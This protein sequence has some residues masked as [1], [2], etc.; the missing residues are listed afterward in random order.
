MQGRPPDGESALRV[1]ARLAPV[2]AGTWG[3]AGVAAGTAL[4]RLTWEVDTVRALALSLSTALAVRHVVN[5]LPPR[6]P[7]NHCVDAEACQQLTRNR[8]QKHIAPP[9]AESTARMMRASL[10]NLSKTLDVLPG[11]V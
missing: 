2:A 1:L 9:A 4:W 11:C 10:E 3:L 5:P 6:M 7:V 8:I